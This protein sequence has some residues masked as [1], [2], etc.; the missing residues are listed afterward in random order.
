MDD[1]TAPDP[2]DEYPADL[3]ALPPKYSEDELAM[4]FSSRYA[5]SL[6]YVALFGKWY[7]WKS[8][9]W[10]EDTTLQVYDLARAVCRA[11]SEE[12]D[13]VKE[14]SAAKSIAH[15]KTVAAVE[16]MAKS[17]RRHASTK[18]QF[19]SFPWL[20]NTPDGL[21]DLQKSQALGPMPEAYSTKVTGSVIDR[22]TGCP[23]W[24]A[25]LDRVFAG[26]KE[27]ISYIR[28]VCGYCLTGST[29]D[30]ALFF[31]YGTG[32]NGKSVFINTLAGIL[33]DYHRAAPVEIF[34]ESNND[35]HPTELAMLM[36]ARLVTA[37]ETEEGRRWAESRVKALTGGDPIS[38]RFMRQDFFEF[39]PQFKLMIAGNHKPALRTVDEAIRRRLNLIPFT[40]TIPP[41]ER[42]PGLTDALKAEWPA[43]LGWM[44]AG[45]DEWRE[46][47]L[48]APKA[49][50]LATEAYLNAE[51]SISQWI[52]DCCQR[53]PT[54]FESDANLYASYVS[55]ANKSG[56]QPGKRK[57]F[58]ERLEGMGCNP[59]RKN[60]DRGHKGLIVL[61][62][63]GDY[64]GDQER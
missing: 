19:D 40:V 7:R 2:L 27:L 35:R 51:D 57:R 15:S 53:S 63:G 29:R 36:G 20:L 54:A 49:V 4:R 21:Y 39:K 10:R 25:F 38:A 43:I 18:D 56:E 42:D 24:E 58:L 48:Q 61:G 41:E 34:M 55:W 31:L 28:R 32:A 13:P 23:R 26:D 62:T 1:A 44:V 59:D 50:L 11:A 17:D 37:V 8:P 45:C 60:K 64:Y 14:K 46:H 30:H 33:A 22:G 47:G 16:R 3:M 5:D 6:R 12:L 9:V 52:A